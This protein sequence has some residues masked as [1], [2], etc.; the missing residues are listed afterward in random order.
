[1]VIDEYAVLEI[2]MIKNF[3]IDLFN[4]YIK[5]QKEN[6]KD[7]I[8][9]WSVEE[10]AAVMRL[11]SPEIDFFTNEWLEWFGTWMGF[12]GMHYI[13][14]CLSFLRYCAARDLYP[15]NEEPINEDT[16]I[17]NRKKDEI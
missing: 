12:G 1:M 14:E 3:N 6:R 15:Y 8:G 10:Y 11:K 5:Y 4:E 7:Y 13:P 17:L 2:A 16:Q 9:K